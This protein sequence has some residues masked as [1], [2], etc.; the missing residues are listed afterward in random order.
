LR[1]VLDNATG[2]WGMRVNHVEL[3]AIDP[4]VTIQ[5][6]MEKEMRA[7]RGACRNP[8][9]AALVARRLRS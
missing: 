6:A 2:C 9:K 8:G 1:G 3:K 5:E 7:E 4:P